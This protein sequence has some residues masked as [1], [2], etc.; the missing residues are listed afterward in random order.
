MVDARAR[1]AMRNQQRE[2]TIRRFYNLIDPTK[3]I[4]FS[5]TPPGD[6]VPTPTWR[7]CTRTGSTCLGE[8]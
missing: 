5:D 1:A 4:S 3:P 6:P 7:T 2:D 8:H